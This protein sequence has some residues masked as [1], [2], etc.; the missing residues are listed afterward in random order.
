MTRAKPNC[1]NALHQLKRR[2]LQGETMQ[3]VVGSYETGKTPRSIFGMGPAESGAIVN[4][5]HHLPYEAIQ[6]LGRGVADYGIV[7]G[8]VTHAAIAATC[9]R[10]GFQPELIAEDWAHK[11]RNTERSLVLTAERLIADYEAAPMGMRK[12]AG[13][14]EV[15]RMTRIC[16]CWELVV[17][18][19]STLI[20]APSFESE[21]GPLLNYF[22]KRSFDEWLHTLTEE[23]PFEIDVMKCPEFAA[24][25]MKHKASIDKDGLCQALKQ[26]ILREII[27]QVMED[28]A[29][30][31][32]HQEAVEKAKALHL[33][34]MT[35]TFQ[36][37]EGD[38]ERDIELLKQWAAREQE[39]KGSWQAMVLT[40]KRKRY[41]K[42]LQT[43]RQY[44]SQNFWVREAKL[45][46]VEGEVQAFRS[47]LEDHLPCKPDKRR[48]VM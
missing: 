24:V 47:K 26:V 22:M 41:V 16:K 11:M 35:A 18:K 7:K 29:R 2:C 27:P 30:W 10:L 20:P 1:F 45:C 44:A 6:C 13:L 48:S 37:M 32:R 17:A 8:P 4:L 40:H 3:Q 39:R 25:V 38:L 42:G 23:C 34:V 33:Q 9:F 36:K 15:S 31:L 28:V 14:N 19:L 12:S 5:V 46:E 21:K 43:V